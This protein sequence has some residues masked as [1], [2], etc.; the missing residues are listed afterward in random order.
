MSSIFDTAE[1]KR[2]KARWKTRTDELAR[3]HAYYN[4]AIYQK[5]LDRLKWLKSRISRAVKPLYVP[6]FR[7]VNV[8]AGIIPGEWLFPE[9]GKQ[10]WEP[11]RKALWNSSQWSTK[12]VLYVHYGS[13]YGVSGLKVADLRHEQ[14]VVV[15]PVDPTRFMLLYEGQYSEAAAMA[16]WCEN[17]LDEEGK[18]FEY[19]EVITPEAIRTFKDGKAAGYD[20]REAE[21]KNELGFVPYVE[22]K[23]IETGHPLGESTFDNV[24]PMLDEVNA[25]A[26]QL[27]DAIEK[28]VEPQWVIFGADASD[29]V[30]GSDN[31]W[32]VA[33]EAR[34]EP[35]VPSI[36]IP[37]VMEFIREIKENVHDALPELAFDELRKK[38]QIATATMELQLM[39]LVLKTKRSRPN[40][41]AGLVTAMQMAGKA[42]KSMNLSDIAPLDD[43]ELAIDAE[44][45]VLPLDP[46]TDIRIQMMQLELER[47]KALNNP[48]EGRNDKGGQQL[49]LIGME[50]DEP[51]DEDVQQED[52][53][54]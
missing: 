39:E 31:V 7:A 21:Y 4:G 25:L 27:G 16:I 51:D 54:A 14:R 22:V 35:V 40:Y 18:Q 47:Q 48:G 41:D 37:G 29:L 10:T 50:D 52:D 33:R 6:L 44:R 32:F 1:F 5:S 13:L 53:A 28:N 30:K 49:K 26:S 38:D 15:A 46:E 11:A 42:A 36:D 23:H 34:V 2:Y 9:E 17:R 45:P 8:D 3:R 19:A 12:G 43:D 24:C 20:E